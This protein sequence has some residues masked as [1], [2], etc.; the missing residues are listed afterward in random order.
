MDSQL[1]SSGQTM[2]QHIFRS[3]PRTSF[4]AN[5]G[6]LSKSIRGFIDINI[7]ILQNYDLFFDSLFNHNFF[8]LSRFNTML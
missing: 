8:L 7:K 5:L 1:I 3:N 2:K 4:K 6:F